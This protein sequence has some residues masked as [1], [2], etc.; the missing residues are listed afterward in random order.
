[1]SARGNRV[2]A[3]SVQAE[4]CNDSSDVRDSGIVLRS[5]GGADSWP[6]ATELASRSGHVG[7]ARLVVYEWNHVQPGMLSWTFPS[8]RAALVAVRTMTNAGRWV[9]VRGT[10]FTT[11]DHAYAQGLVVCDERAFARVS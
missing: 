1:M 3:T 9:I 6:E 10:E 8:L 4:V 5:R 7:E 11:L 2:A